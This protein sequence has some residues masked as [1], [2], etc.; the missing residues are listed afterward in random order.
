MGDEG[1]KMKQSRRKFAALL[2]ALAA[3]RLGAQDASK[4][5]PS[6]AYV[7]EQ[8]P[9]KSGAT[10]KSHAVFNGETHTGYPVEVH[11]TELAA[12]GSPH[13]PHQHLHEEMFLMQAGVLDATVNG[14]TT[15]LTAGSVFYINSNDLHGVKNPGPD[16]AEYFV[17]ALGPDV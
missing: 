1:D 14:K 3:A 10:S 12:G 15:R 5:L 4:R 2:P 6:K 13:P 9:T 16:R 17:V 7:F 8:L 11:V